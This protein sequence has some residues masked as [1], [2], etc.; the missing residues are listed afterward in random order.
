LRLSHL[1][2]Q[3]AREPVA[4]GAADARQLLPVPRAGQRDEGSITAPPCTEGV[5]WDRHEA[6][7]GT[8]RGPAGTFASGVSRQV[9]P[10]AHFAEPRRA[11]RLAGRIGLT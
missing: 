2:A 4:N 9:T 6:A 5:P 11:G 8:I 10:R 1:S 7:A 3:G